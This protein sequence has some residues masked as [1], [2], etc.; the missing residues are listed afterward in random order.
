MVCG[1][2]S[3]LVS[4]LVRDV[5]TLL[6]Y[7]YQNIW[8]V[9][10]YSWLALDKNG[11]FVKLFYLTFSQYISEFIHRSDVINITFNITFNIVQCIT[12][13]VHMATS[14]FRRSIRGKATTICWC[15]VIHAFRES[16]A[17][18]V[19]TRLTIHSS[20]LDFFSRLLFVNK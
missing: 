16:C 2:R 5:C 8:T 7:L 3:M 6:L 15:H 11:N 17:V 4:H 20:L 19:L 18:A 14:I 13:S 12:I 10:K 9:C 1:W